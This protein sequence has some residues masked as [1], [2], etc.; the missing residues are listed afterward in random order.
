M[1]SRAKAS[2]ENYRT[3]S[4]AIE[5]RTRSSVGRE[6]RDLSRVLENMIPKWF[7]LAFFLISLRPS[8]SERKVSERIGND[9]AEMRMSAQSNPCLLTALLPN[10]I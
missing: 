4:G 8:R 10:A 5:V 3:F 2:G 9:R 7:F 1:R 6:D